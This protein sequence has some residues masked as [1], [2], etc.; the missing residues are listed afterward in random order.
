[1]FSV[2]AKKKSYSFLNIIFKLLFFLC[3]KKQKN[4]C[5]VKV[6]FC[7]KFKN[8]I[9]NLLKTKA[10]QTNEV[11]KFFFFVRNLKTFLFYVRLVDVEGYY[12][13]T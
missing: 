3:F 2:I 4:K 5:I 9:I 10:T 11:H 6:D 13:L 12:L 7:E 1:M 8:E